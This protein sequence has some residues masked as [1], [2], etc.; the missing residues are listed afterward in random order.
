MRKR[1]GP[2]KKLAPTMAP[3]ASCPHSFTDDEGVQLEI[4][5]SECAGA[6]DLQNSK[7]LIGIV[8]VMSIG[9]EPEAIILKRFTHKR[10][11]GE[12]IKQ[13]AS[14]AAEL[15]ALNRALVAM[16]NPSDKR[17]RTC[18]ASTEHVI[19]TMRKKLM[20]NPAE[21]VSSR[22]EVAT[23]VDVIADS[24]ACASAHACANKGL[25]AGILTRGR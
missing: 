19:A 8:N 22:D 4:D 24:C 17:C 21:Y 20:E 25:S 9:A 12:T 13:A 18:A 16:E 3:D 5:C 6:H 2:T 11:R 15:A 7:C 1:K 14:A 23:E 10:Y